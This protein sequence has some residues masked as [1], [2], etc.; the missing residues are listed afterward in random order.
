M[1]E[2][3][4][5]ALHI[6][7]GLTP[8]ERDVSSTIFTVFGLT[9]SAFAVYF[10]LRSIFSLHSSPCGLLPASVISLSFCS[11]LLSSSLT[12]AYSTFVASYKPSPSLSSSLPRTHTDSHSPVPLY[13]SLPLSHTP[14]PNTPPHLQPSE[15]RLSLSQPLYLLTR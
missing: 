9:S 4:G 5:Q 2:H 15:R 3:H 8:M 14:T 7:T 11:V 12:R 13:I 10:P 6:T 1:Q